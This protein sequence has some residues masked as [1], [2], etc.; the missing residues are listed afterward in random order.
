MIKKY[1]LLLLIIGNTVF[2]FAQPNLNSITFPK[3]VDVYNLYEISFKLGEYENL[4]DPEVIDVYAVF[5]SPEGETFRV[6]GFYFESYLFSEMDG[7]EVASRCG[8]ND[9]WKIRF[10]P[11]AAGQWTFELH[12]I[13]KNGE[14]HLTSYHNLPFAFDCRQKNAEGFIRAANKMYLKREEFVNGQRKYHS[15]FPVGPNVAWY[16]T[17][18]YY[19]FKKPYGIYEYIKYID[20]LE[21]KANY[22][23]IWLTRYQYLSLYGPEHTLRDKGK[24]VTYFDSSINQKDAAELDFIVRYAADH[25]INLMMCLFTFGDFRDDSEGLE[26]S[27]KY[28]SMPSGWRYNPFHTLLHLEQPAEFFS[29]AEAKRISRNLIRYIVARWGYATNIECWELW[30]EV[31]NTFKDYELDGTEEQA[32][33]D[34]HNEMAEAIRSF[35]PHQH[36]VTTSLGSTKIMPILHERCFDHLDVVQNHNY[37]NIQKSKSKEQMSYILFQKSGEMR[38]MYPE[39][40]C[41]M[42]EYGLMG[43]TSGNKIPDK[44]PKGIDLHN[45]LWS[46]V[47]SGSMGPAS[48]WYWSVLSTCNLFHRFEPINVFCNNLPVLSD[49]FT[50]KTTGTAKKSTL[51]F[52]NHLATYYM[53]NADEDTLLGWSQDTAFCYQSLR[54]LTDN[55]GKNGHFANEGV[56]DSKGYVYTLDK[57]KRPKSSSSNNAIAIPIKKQQRGTRYEVRWFDTE[58]GLEIPSEKT[59]EVVRRRWFRKLLTIQFPSSIR[60]VNNGEITNTF[61]DAVFV[62]TKIND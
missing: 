48:Y 21:G 40:P 24:P 54:R 16:T 37:Q 28:N 39:K 27:A 35:D 57:T 43:S 36:L 15:F 49:T 4:Y 18:D 13:D 47:F 51:T 41:F 2:S 42:G 31:A 3:S 19:Y 34:W 59:T 20:T 10:T 52:P 17:V 60:D 58:T 45:S 11:N 62:V 53:I 44:D 26:K 61:G 7:V 5:H 50:A 33:I 14:I 46:S 38:E 32:I 9:S 6:N 55:V 25:N 12:A 23:R 1:I 30:N 29:D 22:M 56:F 8:D